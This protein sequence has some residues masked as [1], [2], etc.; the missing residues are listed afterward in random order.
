MKYVR[1]I[2]DLKKY[3]FEFFDCFLP[4]DMADQMV[5]YFLL[6]LGDNTLMQRA[7][8]ILKESQVDIEPIAEYGG[9][10][11][12]LNDYQD[13][14]K[15][16]TELLLLS[17]R[18][19]HLCAFLNR[20]F[21]QQIGDA[22]YK[23]TRK[24]YSIKERYFDRFV[25]IVMY[26]QIDKSL[27]TPFFLAIFNCDAKSLM[28]DY[29]E[30]LKEYLDIFLKGGEDDDFIASLLSSD[31][32]NGISEYANKN[33]IKTLNVL[34]NGF[35]E[36]EFTN[37]NIIKQAL[38][39]HRQEGLNIIE[40]F[41][42]S[43]DAEKRF[44]ATQL[45][46]LVND[47]RRVKDR[48]KY[49]YE[50]TADAKIK[51]L[52]EKECNFNSLVKFNNKEEF[53]NFVDKATPQIQERLYGARL[54]RHYEK[55]ELLNK[56]LSGKTLTFIMETFKNREADTQLCYL[57]DF[58]KYVDPIV[59]SKLSKVVYE[60]AIYRE[61]LLSSKWALRL[62]AVFGS[63]ELLV[64]MTPQ[65]KEWFEC[66]KSKNSAKYFID[67]LAECARPEI[68]QISK[69]LLLEGGLDKKQTKFLENKI[70]E[71]SKTSRQNLEEVKDKLSDDLGFD[72]NG[73]RV[74]K[75]ESRAILAQINLDC[76]ISLTNLKTKKPARLKD[77]V[78]WQEVSLK[79]Y[80]K[81]LEK[82]VKKQKKRLYA[83][84][85][86]F[87]QYDEE[88]FKTCILDNPLLNYLSQKLVW[89][90]Y[91]KDKLSEICKLQDNKLL[92][93]AGNI[94][95]SD[96]NDYKIAL[97]QPFDCVDQKERLK[98][99]VGETLFN[100]FDFPVFNLEGYNANAVDSLSGVFCNAQLFITR[101]QKL[102]YKV[103]DLD[104]KGQYSTLVKENKNLNLLTCVEFERVT[105]GR[106]VGSTT[107][108]KVRF[109][110]LN[111]QRRTGKTYSLNKTEAK[112]VSEIE[113]RVLSNEL[114]QIF[115]ACKN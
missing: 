11:L 83:A 44:K 54:K 14:L 67:L 89:A 107:I 73:Q 8:N 34:L 108:S 50:N 36:G 97:L 15:K 70:A 29:K 17:T 45:L 101:L 76:S 24:F 87:R 30:P 74:F 62:I 19:E 2:D 48:L 61:K 81:S 88:S 63:S 79:K 57:K 23:S 46:L 113:P 33:T 27:Y 94:I 71:F 51:A 75:L 38:V 103:N 22:K 91:K 100:Q 114:A 53:F 86:E 42:Q 21:L 96:Y 59:L 98:E 28:F 40:A 52:L 13:L 65:V 4:Q 6:G 72:Q 95:I 111:K 104:S 105:M 102:K 84:F 41:L 78:M 112:I 66:Q 85:L 49:L 110:D 47:E 92:H 115:I 26:C 109:Y 68:V 106:E 10:I 20:I 37:S 60:V 93:V 80:I 77:D 55:E 25:E 18:Y 1:N 35:V 3:T 31:S 56:G 5:N 32:K 69:T 90:R 9:A 39:K 99:K 82:E 43:D 16:Y 58:F 12:Q 7:A 64:N